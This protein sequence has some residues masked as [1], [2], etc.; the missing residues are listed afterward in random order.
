MQKKAGREVDKE[1]FHDFEREL[2]IEHISLDTQELRNDVRK[3]CSLVNDQ[4]M[5]NP[6]KMVHSYAGQHEFASNQSQS[7]RKQYKSQTYNDE[8]FDIDL[9][10]Q[11]S[12][13]KD[14]E[15]DREGILNLLPA[16]ESGRDRQGMDP[17]SRI[18]SLLN[19]LHQEPPSVSKPLNKYSEIFDDRNVFGEEVQIENVEIEDDGFYPIHEFVNYKSEKFGNSELA[20]PEAKD[21]QPGSEDRALGIL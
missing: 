18:D 1:T 21:A 6:F 9:I 8:D 15:T 16:E 3:L 11:S 4:S 20:L 13:K 10:D 19:F 14:F 5:N 2:D 12:S 7:E 17:V